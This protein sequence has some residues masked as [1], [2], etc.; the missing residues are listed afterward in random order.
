TLEQHRRIAERFCNQGWTRYWIH[1]NY[2]Q[3]SPWLMAL[4][5][6][7]LTLVGSA[8]EASA[9]R[10]YERDLTER[11]YRKEVRDGLEYWIVERT[12]EDGTPYAAPQATEVSAP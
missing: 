2:P 7:E 9:G 1:F 10:V 6:I 3:E 12:N 4:C 8:L 5:S 11:G